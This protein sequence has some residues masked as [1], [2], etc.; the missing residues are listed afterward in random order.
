MIELGGRACRRHRPVLL[1]YL[2]RSERGP[3]LER[4]LDHLAGCRGCR[5]DLEAMALT[6]TALRRLSQ[7]IGE[8]EPSSDAWERLRARVE[9]KAERK[10]SAPTGFAA[11]IQVGAL[12][13]SA[14]I[15]ALVSAPAL[16]MPSAS[17]GTHVASATSGGSSSR[18]DRLDARAR[19]AVDPP[20]IV[21]TSDRRQLP[22][23]APALN[24]MTISALDPSVGRQLSRR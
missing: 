9:K 24:Q 13:A 4:A 15:V 12:I 3:G 18:G 7:A 19:L 16:I 1:N 5:Y 14:W 21:L 10:Y 20:V 2:E 11:L 23:G 8:A 6:I 17:T 22:D